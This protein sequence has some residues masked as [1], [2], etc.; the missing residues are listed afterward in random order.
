MASLESAPEA[1]YVS[2][3]LTPC[4][5]EADIGQEGG[6]PARD[7]D[8]LHRG[9]EA[10]KAWMDAVGADGRRVY[11]P[12]KLAEA[13]NLANPYKEATLRLRRRWPKGRGAPPVA[14]T[15][16]T[17]KMLEVLAVEGFPDVPGEGEP[18]ALSS[19]HN[20]EMP[21]G[22]VAALLVAAREAGRPA[23]DWYACSYDATA[24]GDGK[25]LGD[26]FGMGA[27]ARERWLQL[28]VPG[29]TGDLRTAAG[30]ARVADELRARVPAGVA[31]YTSD[32]G[33]DVTDDYSRQ[34][35]ANLALNYGQVLCGLLCLRPGGS[36]LT[37]QYSWRLPATRRLIA[38]LLPLFGTL[39][40]VKPAT[41]KAANGEVYLFGSD[42]LGGTA[43]AGDLAAA[44]RE[45][46]ADLEAAGAA[47][48]GLGDSLIC[49]GLA[50]DLYSAAKSLAA[51]Q[52]AALDWM[53]QIADMD[54]AARQ[55]VTW[56]GTKRSITWM[57][58]T[59][60]ALEG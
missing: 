18:G 51:R 11:G 8:Q 39:S 10:A 23:P 14:A 6:Q 21:G 53:H 19:F 25:I 9:V 46:A 41:S 55:K 58:K 37:K 31:L 56:R 17:L 26:T 34:E 29:L 45:L 4:A 2:F 22:F 52:I 24:A 35:E 13:S 50:E 47:P 20:A 43:D 38:R 15:N 54:E 60:A 57:S 44:I 7:Y 16:A 5:G 36:L 33:T 40:I 32:A 42:F 48:E 12:K 3:I 28:A 49:P 27:W 59:F 30:V 1:D